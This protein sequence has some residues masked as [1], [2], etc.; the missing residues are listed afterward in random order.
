MWEIAKGELAYCKTGYLWVIGMFAV[1]FVIGAFLDQWDLDQYIM[2][3]SLATLIICGLNGKHVEKRN[4]QLMLLPIKPRQVA[5]L[6]FVYNVALLALAF[7]GWIVFILVR[8]DG[9]ALPMFWA[10]LSG[11]AIVLSIIAL[12]TM[13]HDF[14]HFGTRKLRLMSYGI[15]VLVISSVVIAGFT[16]LLDG[17]SAGKFF[18]TPLAVLVYSLIFLMLFTSS[19]HVFNRRKSYLS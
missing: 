1:L 12:L 4:R 18:K 11:A 5:V 9:W 15:L 8:P 13:H 7:I 16:G 14:A 17:L 19:I 3:T 2:N 6:R 10:M